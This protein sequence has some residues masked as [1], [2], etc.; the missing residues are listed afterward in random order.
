MRNL[1]I[2]ISNPI[3]EDRVI[4]I[5]VEHLEKYPMVK[6][7]IEPSV[8]Q[9]TPLSRQYITITSKP[10]GYLIIAHGHL[11]KVLPP[12]FK[13]EP[14]DLGTFS[15]NWKGCSITLNYTIFSR[16]PGDCH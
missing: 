6:F 7:E 5:P 10:R 15:E 8:D 13:S 4:E 12:T 16:S 1:V 9:V 14:F 11:E 3:K 2:R